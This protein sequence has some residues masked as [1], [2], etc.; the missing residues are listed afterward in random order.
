M[1]FLGRYVV[2]PIEKLIFL[3]M[4]GEVVVDELNGGFK[5]E[6]VMVLLK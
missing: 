4:L 3:A 2:S 6:V 1:V 5:V